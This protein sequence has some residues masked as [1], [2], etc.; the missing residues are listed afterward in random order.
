MTELMNGSALAI[1]RNPQTTHHGVDSAKETVD[2]LCS[3][4]V[5]C[6]CLVCAC[7]C[8]YVYSMCVHACMHACRSVYEGECV[9]SNCLWVLCVR[10]REMLSAHT[11]LV[12]C[13]V[14]TALRD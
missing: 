3:S 4:C 9:N 11:H 8:V 7:V 14:N 10:A 5:P 12:N 2:W 13:N 6:I 1:K